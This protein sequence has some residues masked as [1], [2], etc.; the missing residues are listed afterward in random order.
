MFTCKYI[1]FDCPRPLLCGGSQGPPL[2]VDVWRLGKQGIPAWK[3]IFHRGKGFPTTGNHVPLFPPLCWPYILDPICI[4]PKCWNNW[5][6]WQFVEECW[7]LELLWTRLLYW[8][9]TLQDMWCFC[10]VLNLLSAQRPPKLK[11][12]QWWGTHKPKRCSL[13]ETTFRPRLEQNG[14]N[15][16]T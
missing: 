12:L 3:M 10:D 11:H 1:S 8:P 14:A 16:Q 4:F 7:N 15:D 6:T 9:A 5:R 2:W 13:Q